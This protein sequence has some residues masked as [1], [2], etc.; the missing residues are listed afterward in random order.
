MCPH[1]KTS[2][3][4]KIRLVN[5]HYKANNPTNYENE[6]YMTNSTTKGKPRIV[7]SMLA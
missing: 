3:L 5:I 2:L 7:T 1:S 4:E 6:I